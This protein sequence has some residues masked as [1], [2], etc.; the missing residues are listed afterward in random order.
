MVVQRWLGNPVL[1]PTQNWWECRA[2]FN[3]GAVYHDGRVHLLYRALG[4]DYLSRLGYASSIDGFNFDV[5][6]STPVLESEPGDEFE[7][8]G[9]EDPRVTRIDGKF[10]ITYTAASVY[11]SSNPMPDGCTG[12]PWRVRVALASTDDFQTFHRHGVVIPD[13]D[14]KNAALFPERVNGKYLLLHRVFPNLWLCRS[15]DLLHWDAHSVLIEPRDGYWDSCKVGAGAPPIRTDMG[16]LEFY[17]GVSCEGIYGLGVLL[18]DLENPGKTLFRSNTPI[19]SP[20]K[21][22]EK[23]GI[24][25]NVVFTCGAVEIDGRYFVYY[26]GADKAIG[27]AV[28]D[29]DELL[30]EIAKGIE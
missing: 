29:R 14:S 16:W 12:A 30:G 18:L 10:Y 4:D 11:P 23:D 15:D 21:E 26:G 1:E 28:V 20:S 9:C 13:T 3:A 2:V 5:R 25:P 7:R 27:V 22:F 19:L 8:L 17:H 6:S 24:V